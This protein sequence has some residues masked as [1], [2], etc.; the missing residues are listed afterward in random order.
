MHFYEQHPIPDLFCLHIHSAWVFWCIFMSSTQS[1]TSSAFTFTARESFDAFQWAA[2]NPWPLLLSHSQ[3]V[4]LLMHFYEQHP[5]PDLFCHHIHSL[6]V[7]GCI[8]MSSTQSLTS[9]AITFTVRESFHEQHPIADLFE[10]HIH[11]KWVFQCLLMSSTQSLA[12]SNI[13]FTGSE[14]S[15]SFLWLLASYVYYICRMCVIHHL[16]SLI[17]FT[18][19]CFALDPSSHTFSPAYWSVF[20]QL[21][22][23]LYVCGSTPL[24]AH[25][26]LSLFL[27]TLLR[28][29]TQAI[30]FGISRDLPTFLYLTFLFFWRYHHH[31][32]IC[33]VCRLSHCAPGFSR[34]SISHYIGDIGW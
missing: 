8:F 24:L 27:Q 14:S 16:L 30:I 17:F 28:A 32:A 19:H 15:E 25:G 2:P 5:I 11:R 7:F 21:S 18:S 22:H 12:S 20:N 31:C 3:F 13:T 23:L 29:Q 34:C 1:L 26:Y 10:H 4:S 6:W 33:V 9:S